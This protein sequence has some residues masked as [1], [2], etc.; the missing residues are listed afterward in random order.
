MNKVQIDKWREN[1]DARLEE[2]T[3]MNAK[4]NSQLFHI[5]TTLEEIKSMVKEQNGRVRT[6]EQQTSAMK[7]IGSIVAIAYSAV[8]TWLFNRS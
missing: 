7:A 4:Q 6:L 8:I 2:L 5:G 1:V 3:V